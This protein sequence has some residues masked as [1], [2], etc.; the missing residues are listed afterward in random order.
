MGI[1]E[2]F[3]GIAK[4]VERFAEEL[5]E[6]RLQEKTCLRRPVCRAGGTGRGSGRQVSRTGRGPKVKLEKIA[7]PSFRQN[8]DKT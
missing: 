6:Q 7:S 3:D 4:V 8:H 2:L 5:A 1:N